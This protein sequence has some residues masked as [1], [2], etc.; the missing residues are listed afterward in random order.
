MKVESMTGQFRRSMANSR[1]PRLI[2]SLAN[3]FNPVLFKNDPLPSTRTHTV[4]LAVP[5]SMEG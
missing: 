1:K 5:T 2:I 4:R 3:S